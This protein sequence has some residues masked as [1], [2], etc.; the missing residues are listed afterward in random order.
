MAEA[1]MNVQAL[2][3]SHFTSPSASPFGASRS[4]TAP[5]TPSS[6]SPTPRSA[7]LTTLSAMVP[8][9]V[10]SASLSPLSLTPS[11]PSSLKKPVRVLLAEDEVINQKIVQRW[12]GQLCKLTVVENGL[13]AITVAES[14]RNRSEDF[15]LIFMVQPLIRAFLPV[16][17]VQSPLYGCVCRSVCL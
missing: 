6:T 15:D 9:Q 10:S 16:F 7:K 2:R 5:R 4:I 8:T 12:L 3:A 11:P 14:A 13:D 17:M 1:K